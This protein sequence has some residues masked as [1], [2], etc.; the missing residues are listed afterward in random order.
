M[1]ERGQWLN[2]LSHPRRLMFPIGMSSSSLF[3]SL[4]SSLDSMAMRFA[5]NERMIDER[6]GEREVSRESMCV[7]L[8]SDLIETVQDQVT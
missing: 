7:G 1:R 3:A 8:V 2:V 6:E 4:P 5:I